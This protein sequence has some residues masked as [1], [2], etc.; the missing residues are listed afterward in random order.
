MIHFHKNEVVRDGA[1]GGNATEAKLSDPSGWESTENV[2]SAQVLELYSET[3]VCNESNGGACLGTKG[4]PL[5]NRVTMKSAYFIQ[6]FFVLN[7][8]WSLFVLNL[9]LCHWNRMNYEVEVIEFGQNLNQIISKWYFFFCP[10]FSLTPF[11]S[12]RPRN[13]FI[14]SIIRLLESQGNV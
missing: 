14:F 12:S 9:I 10:F 8:W 2:W 13:T 7:L 6:V 4:A 3:E 5:I 11:D 1:F